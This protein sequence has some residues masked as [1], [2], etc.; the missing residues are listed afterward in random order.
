[1]WGWKKVGVRSE[2]RL[3]WGW[4]KVCV[5]SELQL[6]GPRLIVTK[7]RGLAWGGGPTGRRDPVNYASPPVPLLY[8]QL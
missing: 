3:Q 2:L 1:M 7:H 8:P 5:R 6:Q 4:K